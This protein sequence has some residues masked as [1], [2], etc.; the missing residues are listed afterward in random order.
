M[1][2]VKSIKNVMV[3]FNIVAFPFFFLPLGTKIRAAEFTPQLVLFEPVSGG[4]L[5]FHFVDKV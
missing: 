4:K 5:S 2:V 3:S 1:E